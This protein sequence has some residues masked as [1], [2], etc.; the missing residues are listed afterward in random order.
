MGAGGG[1]SVLHGTESQFEEMESSG[2]GW[3]GHTLHDS[4]N[5]LDDSVSVLG[6]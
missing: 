2:D 3:W 1:E 6:C 4:V 5:V